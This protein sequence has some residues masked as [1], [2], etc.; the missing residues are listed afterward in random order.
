MN[1]LAEN[2][3]FSPGS[4]GRPCVNDEIAG[5]VDLLPGLVWA[6]RPDGR[7]DFLSRRWREY[8][9]LDL[10]PSSHADWQ[11]AI[12][13]EDLPQWLERWRSSP[14]SDH[15]WELELRLRRFDGAYRW[16]LCRASPE[17]DA[18]DLVIRWCGIN[19]DID[20]RRRRAERDL[21]TVETNFGGWVESF[22][23]LMVT[24]SLAGQVELFSSEVLEYFGKSR[25]EL[26]TWAMTD[27]VHPDD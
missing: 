4:R 3:P 5:V 13:P 23:G 25:E 8:T 19:T 1:R 27:A 7:V 18:S 24:M 22:P 14:R 6:A 26:R 16:F 2:G 17:T 11:A 15:P 12:H 9:G 10:D 20:D 21:R